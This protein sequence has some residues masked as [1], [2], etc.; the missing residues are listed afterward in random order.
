MRKCIVSKDPWSHDVDPEFEAE[1]ECMKKFGAKIAC[2]NMEDSKLIMP[3]EGWDQE[4]RAWYR[5]WML[6]ALEYEK[7]EKAVHGK[8]RVSSREYLSNHQIDGWYDQVAEFSAKTQWIES[9]EK[10]TIMDAYERYDSSVRWFVKDFSKACKQGGIKP[11]TNRMDF[12][13]IIEKMIQFRG[14]LD[15]GVVLKE[16]IDFEVGSEQRFFAVNG[17]LFGDCSHSKSLEIMLNQ[18]IKKL[19]NRAWVALDVGWDEM[20]KRWRVIELGDGQVSDFQADQNT[21]GL[22]T[23]EIENMLKHVMSFNE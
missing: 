11:I 4:G 2:W 22:Q 9:L 7:L 19:K 6:N 21:R 16:W 3:K 1:V 17:V 18:C 15:R 5:G 12:E 13:T 10:D 20:N 23:F 8:L 14:S